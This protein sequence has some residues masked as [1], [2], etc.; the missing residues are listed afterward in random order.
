M[1][2]FAASSA[3][4]RACPSKGAPSPPPRFCDSPRDDIGSGERGSRERSSAARPTA[5]KMGLVGRGRRT[6]KE[7][8]TEEG[9]KGSESAT[10][11]A[12]TEK[13]GVSVCVCV[14]ER[15]DEGER[16]WREKR[17][18][19]RRR[20]ERAGNSCSWSPF[21]FAFFPPGMCAAAVEGPPPGARLVRGFAASEA[22]R[23]ASAAIEV[24]HGRQPI[25]SFVLL[26]LLSFLLVFLFIVCYSVTVPT[27]TQLSSGCTARLRQ[28][29]SAVNTC[30]SH[31]RLIG[32][33]RLHPSSASKRL[34]TACTG[35][36]QAGRT[37]LATPA[38][39]R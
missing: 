35:G 39:P 11:Q 14:C 7:G 2:F 29:L 22:L 16:E 32:C 13:T 9:R 6:R 31:P 17:E 34:R 37:S 5:R 30:C 15:R 33:D 25:T 18:R 12:Q 38:S 28:A 24:R 27:D 1:G 8:R 23:A 21:F 4:A 36:S 10:T 20:R 26:L 19:K 3:V